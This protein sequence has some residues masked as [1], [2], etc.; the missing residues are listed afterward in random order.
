ME[1]RKVT[2]WKRFSCRSDETL[3]V[4]FVIQS[5]AEAWHSVWL[6]KH[7]TES[8]TNT[9]HFINTWGVRCNFWKWNSERKPQRNWSICSD[10]YKIF[11]ILED[12]LAFDWSCWKLPFLKEECAA[13]KWISVHLT[14]CGS[15]YSVLN[16]LQ[17]YGTPCKSLCIPAFQTVHI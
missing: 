13:K 1:R 6:R 12:C 3:L 11:S 14:Y 5:R 7:K 4:V 16:W 17:P 8:G 2:W 9:H 10:S 15:K